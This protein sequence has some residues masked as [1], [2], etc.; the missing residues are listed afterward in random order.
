MTPKESLDQFFPAMFADDAATIRTLLADDVVWHVPPFTEARFGDL[1]GA[2]AV[3][4]FLCGVG[5]EFYRPGSFSLETEIEAVEGDRGIV[6]GRIRATTVAGKPY[7]NRYAFG[8]RFE[9]GLIAEAW[10]LL[11]SVHFESQM[12]TI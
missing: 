2:E 9:D 10:E 4:G 8:F 11:D 6:M 5:D 7:S 3:V 1:H 12:G